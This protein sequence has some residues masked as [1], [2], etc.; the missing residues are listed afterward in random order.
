LWAGSI[1]ETIPLEEKAI[2][3]SPRDR[4]IGIWYWRIGVVHLLQ[5]RTDEAVPWLEKACVATP[6][7]PLHHAYLAAALAIKGERERAV[8][9]LSEARRLSPDGRYSSIAQLRAHGYFGVAK[10]RALNE[11]T[12]FAGLRKAGMLEE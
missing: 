11:S 6:A 10:I 8:T 1:D 3:L 9:E 7:V 12:Y 5:S 4:G 2:R